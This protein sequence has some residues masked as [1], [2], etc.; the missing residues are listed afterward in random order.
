MADGYGKRRALSSLSTGASLAS[1]GML[2]GGPVGAAV[3]GVAGLVAG[4]LL[5]GPGE[6]EKAYRARL[7][8]LERQAMGLT[9]QE[10]AS[11]RAKVIDPR[12]AA[13]REQQVQANAAG[14]STDIGSQARQRAAMRQQELD[15]LQEGTRA[16]GDIEAQMMRAREERLLNAQAG[17]AGLEARQSAQDRAMLLGSIQSAAGIMAQDAAS[18]RLLQMEEARLAAAQPAASVPAALPPA[19]LPP[20]TDNRVVAMAEEPLPSPGAA[21]IPAPTAP[22]PTVSP[23]ASLTPRIGVL[24]PAAA[25]ADV[26][27]P[28]FYTGRLRE[29]P[30][31]AQ[32]R[33]A[34]LDPL[35]R[36][37]AFGGL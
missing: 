7:K 33:A 37:F 3:G 1:A 18:K 23:P 8:K 36:G 4:A 21:T 34:A 13:I 12:L 10:E 30:Y 6:D 35:A 27:V 31:D 9:P 22:A 32:E 25:A 28:P 29:M 15:F 5:G 16:I 11:L 17:L 19:A 24:S 2:A 20:G 14:L 26:S